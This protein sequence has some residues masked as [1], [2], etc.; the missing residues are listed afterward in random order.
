[1]EGDLVI[2]IRGH[3]REVVIARFARVD[4]QP[5]GTCFQI[6]IPGAF[7]V[8]GSKRLAV[9]PFDAPPRSWKVRPVPS[10]SHDQ[11]VARSGTIDCKLF[12]ATCWSNMIRLLNMP[13]IGP[14][15]LANSSSIDK[16]AILS[17]L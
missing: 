16:L 8:P 6:E 5:F 13:M 4:A 3:C 9:V 2:A 1:M 15:A 12:W 11:L 7:D 17:G 10:S 14:S